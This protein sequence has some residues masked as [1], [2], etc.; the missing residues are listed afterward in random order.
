MMVPPPSGGA[1]LH[2]CCNRT[3]RFRELEACAHLFLALRL[4]FV[5]SEAL[6]LE[7]ARPRV[8]NLCRVLLGKGIGR[9]CARLDI[10]SPE[11]REMQSARLLSGIPAPGSSR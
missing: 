2:I 10:S 5:S 4:I 8:Y 11:M 3:P 6:F 1:M 7:L 9:P